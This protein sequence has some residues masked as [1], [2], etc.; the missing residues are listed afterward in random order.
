M[1]INILYED[2]EILVAEKPVGME[3]QSAKS[4]EPDMVS[5][6]KKHINSKSPKSGEPYVGVIH[7]LDKPV[8]GIMV[9]AKTKNSAESLSK[10]VSGHQMEKIYH[11]VVCGK[12]VENSGT[13]VDYLWKDGKN[14]CS[15]IV[16]KGIK[17]AKPAEL[18]FRVVDKTQQNG[19]EYS[20]LEIKLK[21]GRHHQ[22]R[23]QMA[24][25]GTP[26]WGDQKYN[27]SFQQKKIRAD[28]ALFATSLS[29]VHPVTKK[30]MTYTVKPKG[31][32]FDLF[33]L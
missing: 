30:K 10:Q 16:E 22:I 11:A 6:I 13:Y 12:P 32:M 25:H 3:S 7:R 24:G 18:D 31:Q 27:P 5:E 17:G 8:G 21:T 20:L 15:K 1:N 33:S 9:Y 2:E 23:V 28:I 14:N 19:E 29:F 4:F 26:L